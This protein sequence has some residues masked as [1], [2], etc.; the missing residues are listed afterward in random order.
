MLE[1]VLATIPAGKRLFVELKCGPEG[2][3]EFVRIAGSAPKEPAM[4]VAIGFSRPLVKQ[5]KA[6]MPGLEV[7]WITRFRRNWNTGRRS[8]AIEELIATAR[9]TGLDLREHAVCEVDALPC[10]VVPLRAVAKHCRSG[11]FKLAA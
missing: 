8:R 1:E 4:M 5:V 10:L 6:Q 7:C 3:Q 9:E 2:I 11:R